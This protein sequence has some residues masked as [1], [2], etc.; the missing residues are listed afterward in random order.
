MEIEKKYHFYAAH[1]NEYVEGKCQNLHGHTYYVFVR[2]K[3]TSTDES[4]VSML[5]E[6]IDDVID[7]IIK[8]LD[9]STLVHEQDTL[10]LQAV[11]L[12]NSKRVMFARP[13][14]AENL[15]KYLFDHISASGL[16][17]TE[18]RLQE[19]TSSTVIYP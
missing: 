10:L 2:L 16:K 12:L 14:S 7:P 9:H 18:I 17:V 6:S 4:G 11:D 3:F 5:F 13:T 1:R 15:A 8:T 19:T